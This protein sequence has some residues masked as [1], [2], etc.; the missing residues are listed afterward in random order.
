MKKTKASK[1]TKRNTK[2]VTIE[3]GL[4]VVFKNRWEKT[5]KP[6]VFHDL[7]IIPAVSALWFSVP[8]LTI[9]DDKLAAF[10]G[11]ELEIRWL[12]FSFNVAYSWVRKNK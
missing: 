1:L 11:I 9:P 6:L 5:V 8:C 12:S 2:P 4:Q 3:I 10:R 7:V